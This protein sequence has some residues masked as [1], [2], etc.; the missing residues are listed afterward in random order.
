MNEFEIKWK[1]ALKLLKTNGYVLQEHLGWGGYSVIDSNGVVE[2][3][4]GAWEQDKVIEFVEEY[5]K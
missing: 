1:N 3:Y 4:N 5:L 2:N